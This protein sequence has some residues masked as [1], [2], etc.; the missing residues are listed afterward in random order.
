[1]KRHFIFFIGL[2]YI[3][4]VASCNSSITPTSSLIHSTSIPSNTKTTISTSPQA[5][6][7]ST[8]SNSS[9]VEFSL[10]SKPETPPSGVLGQLLW[11][12]IGGPGWDTP[13]DKCYIEQEWDDP[14]IILKGFAP[15]QNLKLLFYRNEGTV[16][17]FCYLSVY[18]TST[19][20][21]VDKFGSASILL[22]GD[23]ENVSLDYVYDVTTNKLETFS[24]M[25][26][27]GGTFTE[28]KCYACSGAPLQQVEV[29]GR[30]YVCTKTDNLRLRN[31]A[32]LYFSD[33]VAKIETGTHLKIIDGPE[34]NN[35]FY[36]WKVETETG[37]VGWVAEGGDNV[38]PYFICPA[39]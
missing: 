29:G 34:C 27:Q 13:C 1:M 18:L 15:Y 22:K 23:F 39:R 30:A 9:K 12:G 14:T 17:D 24:V 35:G 38:D 11:A 6:R 16:G 20:V 25:G 33:I 28:E 7:T 3:V 21:Q 37:I 5:R 32:G 31:K 8:P 2:L 26:L 4:F 19:T 36:W 10:P